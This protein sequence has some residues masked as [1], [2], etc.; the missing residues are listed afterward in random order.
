MWQKTRLW[1]A[2]LGLAALSVA[3]FWGV[4]QEW[5]YA[6]S[7][8]AKFSTI[9][10]IAYSVLG[11]VAVV[12]LWRRLRWARAML[13]LWAFTMVMTGATAPVIWGQAGWGAALFALAMTGA[14]AGLV[15]WLAPLGPAEGAMKQLRWVVA[16]LSVLSA[17]GVLWVIAPVV[18]KYAPLVLHAKQMEGFCEGLPA[19]LN[20]DRLTALADKQGYVAAPGHDEKGD[21]LKLTDPL[22]PGQYDCTARFKLDGTINVMNFTAGA[23]H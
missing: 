6:A 14:C 3:G 8:A 18:P 10:Q 13:Y 9:M 22:E 4:D 15:I 16:I 7:W 12:P 20:R 21:L 11:V 1:L 2:I 23:K 5:R 19:G 17:L